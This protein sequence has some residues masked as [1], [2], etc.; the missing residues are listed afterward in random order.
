MSKT[1]VAC[2]TGSVARWARERANLERNELASKLGRGFSGEHIA[3]W[4][5][6]SAR[7]TFAQ[8]E[9]LAAK[10]R[11]PLAVLFMR[12]P[13]A[14]TIPLPDLRTVSGKL[15]SKPSLEFLEI[16]NHCVLRQ[17]WYREN[18]EE[19]DA[20]P[21]PFVGRYRVTDRASDVASDI[22]KTLGVTQEMR[23]ETSSWG[24]FLT[25][26]VQQAESVGILVMRSS[27]VRHAPIRKLIVDEFRGFAISDELA[28]LVFINSRDARA[29]Q[30]FTLAHEIAHIWIAS[31]G[32]SNSDPKKRSSDFVHPVERFCNEVAAELL[33]PGDNLVR[34]WDSIE[35]IEMVLGRIASFH[36]VSKIVAIIRARELGKLS[37]EKSSRLINLEYERYRRE[38]EK[39]KEKESGPSFWASFAARNSSRFTEAVL[40]ALRQQRVLHLE[41]ANL[42][43]VNLGTLGKYTAHLSAGQ[44]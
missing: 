9:L 3:A 28:P 1:D 12:E 27:V 44:G 38:S 26:F 20:K 34:M 6:E 35:A 41:A 18:Q 14:I 43:G 32:I 29:A 40:G 15:E 13:P 11:I 42:L 2:I 21:L 4:E 16:I 17:K 22:A 37:Y 23:Q 19:E 5:T 24:E 39:Q 7:P 25:R 31:S 8:A 33:I 30:I 10:L 36:R